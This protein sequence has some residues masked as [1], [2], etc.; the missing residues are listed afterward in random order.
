MLNFD[1]ESAFAARVMSVAN[2]SGLEYRREFHTNNNQYYMRCIHYGT[3]NTKSE[4][5]K[6]KEG[7]PS[8]IRLGCK[9]YIYARLNDEKIT[10]S[11]FINEHNH[12]KYEKKD[13]INLMKFE[14]IPEEIKKYCLDSFLMGENC[15]D[16]MSTMKKNFSAR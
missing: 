6:N 1:N 7:G 9:A 15:S 4:K 3:Y 12:N 5:S 16:I 13:L 14:N 10:I 11:S 2:E 8:T